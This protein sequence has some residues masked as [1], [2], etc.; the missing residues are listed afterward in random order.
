MGK[1]SKIK[2]K[3]EHS[4]TAKNTAGYFNLSY[5]NQ[6]LIILGFT[7]IAFFPVLKA[8]FLNWDDNQYVFD[9]TL[10]RS[11]SNFSQLVT[12]P[13]QGNHHPL[14]MLSLALNYAISGYEPWSYHLLNLLLHLANTFLVY[15][16]ALKLSSQNNVMAFTT[17]L[18]FGI[19]PMHVESVAW[20]AERKD[21]LYS[22]FFLL[23][24]DKY[25]QYRTNNNRRDYLICI[26]W[27]ALSLL[28]KPAAVVFPLVLLAIDFLQKRTWSISVLTEK[29]P[30]FIMALM[31]GILTYNAQS[32]LGSTETIAEFN[33]QHRLLFGFY[34][35]MMYIAKFILP[36][37]QTPFY[38]YP[39]T[40]EAL[41]ALYYLAPLFALVVGY[42]CFKTLKTSRIF[43][44]GI[45]FYLINILL[46]MQFMIVGRAIIAERYTYIPYIGLAFIAGWS[47]DSLS[48]KQK[49]NPGM[50]LIPLA[51]VLSIL[52]FRY[53][54][55]WKNGE[56]LWQHAIEVNPGSRV[57][58]NRASLYRTSGD[59]DKA[60][61]YYSEAL[62]YKDDIIDDAIYT[63]R[64]NVYFDL[65]QYTK[66]ISDYNQSL[67][68]KPGYYQNYENRGASYLMMKNFDSALVDLRKAAELNPTNLSVYNKLGVL[69]L[70]TQK[71]P[72][73]IE[74]YSKY[75][76]GNPEDVE[77]INNLGNCYHSIGNYKEAIVKISMAIS[78]KQKGNFYINRSIAYKGLG[79]LENARKDALEAQRLGFKVSPGYLKEI[80]L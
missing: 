32:E 58:H 53:S 11:F 34:S 5:K 24:L 28:S 45:V 9:N 15:R 46:I 19:H 77:A 36:L 39:L 54:K 51:M 76:A 30:H 74:A 6:L 71:Y 27:F 47:I 43:T 57:Y 20:V 68:I 78:Q 23:G 69:Y 56:T 42:L 1:K 2:Q 3:K 12:E 48:K 33:P 67:K 29:I 26:L 41:P 31:M 10:I 59:L 7:A 64:G 40:T 49:L 13:L 61:E 22:L 4:A 66:A 65:K 8:E 60:I 37:N 75:V 62:K 14:T 44:F 72:E 73:A 63:N 25:L 55:Q 21:V 52:T 38:P 18:L 79:D 70:Q 50:I 17:A 16:L 35:F 80:G